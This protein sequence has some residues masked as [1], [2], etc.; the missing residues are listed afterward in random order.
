MTPPAPCTGSTKIAA[1]VAAPSLQDDALRFLQAPLPV[2]HR[3]ALAIRRV[4]M[5]SGHVD[6]A[7]QRQIEG[8]VATRQTRHARRG[9]GHAVVAKFARD[10][11]RLAGWPRS[12]W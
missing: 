7:R 12:L 1:I 2:S 4:G 5:R 9:E 3:I 11:L 8:R 6:K 10:D